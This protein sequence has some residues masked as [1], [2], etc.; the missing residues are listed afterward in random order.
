MWDTIEK[1]WFNNS[2][3]TALSAIWL[4]GGLQLAI[5]ILIT[6]AMFRASRLTTVSGEAAA[7][8]LNTG[9]GLAAA[10]ALVFAIA[11]Y[12]LVKGLRHLCRKSLT[13]VNSLF[14]NLAQGQSNLAEEMAP[15][16][17]VELN[18]VADGYNAFMMRIREIIDQ[19]R[20]MGIR[21]AIDSTRVRRGV[22]ATGEKTR[23]QKTLTEM[24]ANSSNDADLAIAKVAENAQ[25]ASENT[26]RN[27]DK[28]KEAFSELG[29]VT[30]KVGEINHTVDNFRD[31]VAELNQNT[32]GIMEI[33][34]LIKNISEQTNLLSLNATI[35]AARAGEHGKGFAVVAE[36]VRTLAKRVKTATG[37][38]SSKVENMVTTVEKTMAET[39]VIQGHSGEV[40]QS[41]AQTAEHFEVMITDFE[42]TDD[43]LHKIAAAIEELSL[44]NREINQKVQSIDGLTH[45]IHDSM[46]E[47][48][49]LVCDLNTIT[50]KLQEM[51][52]LY[53]TG[54]GR[55]DAVLTQAFGYRDQIQ[56]QI[57]AMMSK[58]IDV[59]DRQ[60]K[61]VANTN[62][63]KYTTAFTDAFASAFQSYCDE[64]V[65]QIPGAV[66]ALPIDDKGY[67][68]T[69]HAKV[70]KPMTGNYEVDALNSRH[71]RI[72][73]SIE[74]EKRRATNRTPM[75]LQTYMRDT[76]ETLNEFSLP[77]TIDNRHWGAFI[78]G[79]NPDQFL[80]DEATGS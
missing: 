38:I 2:I 53:R 69:H 56:A 78:L 1:R 32:A 21:I 61:P 59:F 52:A 22:T 65:T 79:L 49:T 63:Q 5:T 76:G 10:A 29:A 57:A 64:I 36:E 11:T 45:E 20:Q 51:V 33:V 15:L 41:V 13:E 40:G 37:E 4:L 67:L 3:S 19:V 12:L 62:P 48:E 73:F 44:N 9:M 30:S 31:T 28:A 35:E 71:M 18:H 55:I 75:L 47:A 25:Y 66:Y 24:V 26:G 7:A 17:H 74:S 77:I 70:S 14:E 80:E 39:E 72:F 50:E 34:G 23:E 8:A 43:Q 60:H 68:A 46:A 6:A 54:S 42:G 58:G 27:L 16:P